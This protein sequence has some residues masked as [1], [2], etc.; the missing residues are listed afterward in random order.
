MH[1]NIAL[2]IEELVLHGFSAGDRYR[3]AQAL[4]NELKRLLEERG[5]PL[6]LA[7]N[8]QVAHV[9]GGS[10][11][12]SPNS[13]AEVIGV[14]VA[15]AIYGGMSAHSSAAYRETTDSAAGPAM[16]PNSSAK[17]EYEAL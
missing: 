17:E 14:Q 12:V 7:A 9:S 6:L 8:T 15:R 1:G 16:F 4:E 10:F 11:E 3:I 5:A 2:H 13:K